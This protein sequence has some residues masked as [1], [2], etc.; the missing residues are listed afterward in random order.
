ME[1]L[2]ELQEKTGEIISIYNGEKDNITPLNNTITQTTNCLALTVVKDYKLTIFKNVFKKSF[3]ITWKITL[4][5][6]TMNFL[7][8]FL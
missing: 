1:E 8:T 2:Q 5:I 7:N 4:S 6:I 3:K